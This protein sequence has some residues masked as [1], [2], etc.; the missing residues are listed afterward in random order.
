MESQ[1]VSNS[2]KDSMIRKTEKLNWVSHEKTEF[3]TVFDL[4]LHLTVLNGTYVFI[5][6][7]DYFY[8]YKGPKLVLCRMISLLEQ[9]LLLLITFCPYFLN[10][11]NFKQSN[12]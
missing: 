11:T 6:S 12:Y 7:K 1:L 2:Y 4:Q 5:L 10:C 3:F 8:T 9:Y